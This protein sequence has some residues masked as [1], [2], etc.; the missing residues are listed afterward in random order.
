MD[1]Y[2]ATTELR[3]RG[4]TLPIIA[5]TA[6]AMAEDRDKC[7]AA[8]CTGY[9]TKPV[10]EEKLLKTVQAHLGEAGS[11]LPNDRTAAGEAGS[12]PPPVDTSA[13]NN[14]IKSSHSANP[15]IMEIVPQFVAGLRGKV[16]N[17]TGLLE[18]N[19]L[20]GVQKIAHQLLGSAG[21]YGFAP[22]SQLARTVEQ[23]IQARH[24]LESITVEVKSLIDVIRRID[25][26]DE[27]KEAAGTELFK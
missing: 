17:M 23:S 9:L 18:Q 6:Y 27:S 22:V 11:P 13:S 3:R 8:G 16:S 25:G 2:A 5:L 24:P 14:S 19:D 7:L 21:G 12:P 4:L 1:G 26:Y 15:R 10:D 20:P